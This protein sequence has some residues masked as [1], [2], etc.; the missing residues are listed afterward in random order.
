MNSQG[1]RLSLVMA[2]WPAQSHSVKEIGRVRLDLKLLQN[3]I[4]EW[5]QQ[6][7]CVGNWRCGE[8]MAVGRQASTGAVAKSLHIDKIATRQR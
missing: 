7:G 1:N 4:A 3:D 2:V 5:W 8:N 6:K